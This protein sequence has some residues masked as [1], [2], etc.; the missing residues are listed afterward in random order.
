ML[1]LV[2]GMRVTPEQE[3]QGLDFHEV[4]AP[5]YPG[6]GSPVAFPVFAAPSDRP[7]AVVRVAAGPA[8]GGK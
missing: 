7:V 5:A 1:D 3:M 4:S 2:V 6:D 8:A